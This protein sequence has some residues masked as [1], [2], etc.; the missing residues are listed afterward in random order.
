MKIPDDSWR[1]LLAPY[2]DAEPPAD[3]LERLDRY[4]QLLLRWNLR[5][6][7]TAVRE[8]ERSIPRHFGES[9]FAA[10][11]VPRGTPSPSSGLP[12][13]QT[14]T[15]LDH[16]SGAGFPGLPIAVARPDVAV[17][18]SEAT[19]KKAAFLQEVVR[20]LELSVKVFH[21][22]TEDLPAARVFDCVTMRAVE[23]AA[24]SVPV[25]AARVAAGG[26][27][28]VLGK[29]GVQPVLA[30]EW[31]CSEVSVPNSTGGLWICRRNGLP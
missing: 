2:L 18:L 7:L 29:L 1:R 15:L 26:T 5:M 10:R 11:Y 17:T 25:G 13:G 16:G 21:G 9:L 8:P 28:L 24:E 3:L 31:S 23:R 19:A 4:L 14:L 12:L 6:N 20:E 27:L 30:E 22:R